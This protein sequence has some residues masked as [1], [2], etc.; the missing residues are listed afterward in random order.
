[1]ILMGY[2]VRVVISGDVRGILDIGGYWGGTDGIS[3]QELAAVSTTG[4]HCG[5]H[6]TNRGRKQGAKAHFSLS[7]FG[8][9]PIS[10]TLTSLTSPAELGTIPSLQ[11][12][13]KH[14]LIY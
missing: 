12:F 7:R 2:L 1:M 14:H 8:D 3:G 6:A 13:K 9:Y 10:L 5:I 11:S 4:I